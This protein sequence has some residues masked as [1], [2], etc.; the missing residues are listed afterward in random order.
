MR[1]LTW[2]VLVVAIGLVILADF[3]LVN[4]ALTE[5][6]N[7]AFEIVILIAAG[8]ALAGVAAL[9]IRHGGLVWI[10]PLRSWSSVAV[11][12]G[13]AAVLIAGLYPGS[14]GTADPATQ[15]IVTALLTPLAATLFG[16]LFVTTL[17]AARRTAASG[18]PDAMLLVAAAGVAVVLLLPL[19]G[20]VGGALE[21]AAAW[22]IDV[23]VG[24][25]FNGLLIGIAV[26]AAV[27]AA[28]TLL[29]VSPS[30]E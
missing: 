23:P 13:M 1:L 10:A 27:T 30:D 21:R 6:A 29:G 15:W 17:A 14:E 7:F 24:A 3:L 12:A 22:A 20:G 28:R 11:L 9:A 16:L 4:P 18:R 5:L 25:V 2:P 8:A 19:A 26:L